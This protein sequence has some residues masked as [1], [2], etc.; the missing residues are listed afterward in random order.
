MLN[1]CVPR[2]SVFEDPCWANLPLTDPAVP[3]ETSSLRLVQSLLLQ[4]L[5]QNI[6]NT[7][8]LNS[9]GD[10]HRETIGSTDIVEHESAMWQAFERVLGIAAFSTNIVILI[11]GVEAILGGEPVALTFVD[12]LLARVAEVPN[13]TAILLSRPLPTPSDLWTGEF[14][15]NTEQT[16]GDMMQMVGRA[17]ESIEPLQDEPEERR[18]VVAKRIAQSANGSFLWAQFAIELLQ[19]E[20]SLDGLLRALDKTPKSLG[21]LMQRLISSLESNQG[22]LK[23]VLSWLVVALRP[24]SLVEVQS[25]L[26]VDPR[27]DGPAGT[28]PGGFYDIVR[29]SG[30]LLIVDDGVVRFRHNALRQFLTDMASQGRMLPPLKD[31][32]RDFTSRMLKTLRNDSRLSDTPTMDLTQSLALSEVF[33]ADSLFEYAARYWIVHFHNSSM[34]K[35]NGELALPTEFKKSFPDAVALSIAE[36]VFWEPSFVGLDLS[37]KHILALRI[38]RAALDDKSPA[39]LQ[40]LLNTA[41]VLQRTGNKAEAGKYFYQATLISQN[42]LSSSTAIT[43][44]CAAEYLASAEQTAEK[45]GSETAHF[46]EQMLKSLIEASSQEYGSNSEQRIKYQMAL[47]EL[48][49]ATGREAL[50]A[51]FLDELRNVV[52]ERH[53]QDS[54]QANN[55]NKSLAAILQRRSTKGDN[56]VQFT[57][58]LYLLAEQTMDK[59]DPRRIAAT[60]CMAEAYE[61]QCNF[62]RTEELL[63]DIWTQTTEAHRRS[64]TAE[65]QDAKFGAAIAYIEFLLRRTRLPEATS[66]LLGLWGE[67]DQIQAPSEKVISR[68]SQVAHMLQSAGQLTVAL[69]ALTSI[70]KAYVGNGMQYSNEAAL[71]ASSIAELVQKIQTQPEELGLSSTPPYMAE[72]C[73]RSVQQK[74]LGDQ[75]VLRQVFD[76]RLRTAAAGQLDE[77]TIHM[78]DSISAYHVHQC[79]WVAAIGI[80]GTCLQTVWPS[81]MTGGTAST[82]PKRLPHQA[83]ILADR[84]TQCLAQDHRVEEALQVH[85]SMYEASKASR[86]ADLMAK[87]SQSLIQFYNETKQIDRAIKF[88]D[89]LLQRNRKELGHKHPVT[90]ESLDTLASLC[91][92]AKHSMA[93]QYYEEITSRLD[94]ASPSIGP[95]EFKAAFR[96]SELYSEQGR[97][98]EVVKA[99]EILLRNLDENRMQHFM[100]AQ[101]IRTLHV[102]YTNAIAQKDDCYTESLLRAAARYFEICNNLFPVQTAMLAQAAFELGEA[103]ER[104]E[105]HHWDAIPAY[106]NVIQIA[107][108]CSEPDVAGYV[109]KAEERLA[110]LYRNVALDP[111]RAPP[112]I[113]DCVITMYVEK[114]EEGKADRRCSDDASLAALAELVALYNR[115]G[116]E[117]NQFAALDVLQGTVAEIVSY[118]MSPMRLW[119]SASKLAA[120]YSNNGYGAQGRQI[121][122][123]LRRQAIFKHSTDDDGFVLKWDPPSDRR[124]FVFLATLEGGLPNSGSAT[125]SDLMANLLTESSLLERFTQAEMFGQK[126]INAARLRRFLTSNKRHDLARIL[127][128]RVFD[129]FVAT[130]DATSIPSEQNMRELLVK[131]IEELDNDTHQSMGKSVC[132]AGDKLTSSHIDQGEL[133]DSYE[134]AF[135]AYNFAKALGAYQEVE[136]VV[137]GLRLALYMGGRGVTG[138]TTN[139]FLHNQMRAQSKLILQETIGSCKDLNIDIARMR[140]SELRDLVDLLNEHQ[141][142]AEL[143]VRATRYVCK[144]DQLI[145]H[146]SG[147]LGY[148]G[149]TM[150]PTRLGLPKTLYGWASISSKHASTV[151]SRILPFNYAKTSSIT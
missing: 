126:L 75:S 74:S 132:V 84:L 44:T 148:S 65:L 130:L 38:R 66:I 21:H 58:K 127:E 91:D 12:K 71:V 150:R 11:D 116:T 54:A 93:S 89:E 60:F 37:E 32:H 17:L 106:E 94:T 33:R 35:I 7:E 5:D 70:W 81:V 27:K 145:C 24:L 34:Y 146:C 151:V 8:V 23:S 114:Y 50:A 108:E 51:A 131:T 55:I 96:L 63:V 49:I 41:L 78:C 117:T 111:T 45:G 31:A 103:N 1:R 137:Y 109:A 128:R 56:N 133:V 82:V 102:R 92:S 87:A 47:S 77:A 119:A 59:T 85:L 48:Y 134:V 39:V 120:I 100:T 30:S 69:S 53:G 4:M 79:E 149:P 26:G 107:P 22:N 104:S 124:S 19:K 68:F 105:A 14:A 125:F 2:L 136:N 61:A 42:V 141:S 83:W 112:T 140:M 143:E 138:T 123:V 18:Q 95:S 144:D 122:E 40:S 57:R 6:G 121:V 46:K 73:Q 15:I 10:A 110:T 115:T 13:A 135:C 25:L 118:E 36:G 43:S 98:P 90:M 16:L 113:S 129:A 147:F 139:D 20:K 64:Q 86:D 9:L 142:Y 72:T 3:I 28:A 88:H 80:I 97:W 52:I 76:N 101:T 99:C 29:S 67:C 62:P